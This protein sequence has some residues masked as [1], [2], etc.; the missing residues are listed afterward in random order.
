MTETALIG[1]SCLLGREWASQQ[2]FD[3]LVDR[4]NL[5]LLTGR[6]FGMLAIIDPALETGPLAARQAPEKDAEAV[7]GL[8]HHLVDIKADR[9]VLV[10]TADL[11]P[12][13]G[14]ESAPFAD[15][16][17]DTFLAS[18]RA[19]YDCVNLRFGRV[20]NLFIPELAIPDPAFSMLGTL[21]TPPSEGS[22]PLPLLEHHQLYPAARLAD[23][24][25]KLLPLGVAR[26]VV[27][28]PP[29]TSSELVETLTPDLMDRL[30]VAHKADPQGSRRKS[31]LSFHW[32]DPRDGFLTTKEALLAELA[33][34]LS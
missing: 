8:M 29:L 33:P 30:P 5:R 21:K 14:D 10:T 27:A 34:L 19:L 15:T 13:D 17:D 4:D 9:A 32:L 26:A 24:I 7:A 12:E 6:A 2:Y 20:L 25:N 16:Q 22:L 28:M 18:R 1:S 11:L 31:L 3:D 23:D